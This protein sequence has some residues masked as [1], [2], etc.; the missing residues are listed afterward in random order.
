MNKDKRSPVNKALKALF[1]ALFAVV[2][3]GGFAL[4]VAGYTPTTALS[5][6]YEKATLQ[7][8]EDGRELARSIGSGQ[9]FSDLEAVYNQ[10]Y[11]LR[12]FS[13]KLNNTIDFLQ[14]KSSNASVCMGKNH[15]L[16]EYSYLWDYEMTERSWNGRANSESLRTIVE[17]LSYIREELKESGKHVYVLITPNKADFTE[18]NIPDRIAAAGNRDNENSQ[19]NVDVLKQWLDEYD[20]PYFDSVEYL[21]DSL[22]SDVI[23]FY[24]SGIHYSWAAGYYV[25]QA[26][27]ARIEAETGLPM[28]KFDLRVEAQEGVVF[29]NR[30]LYDLLNTFPEITSAVYADQ[31]QQQVYIDN[32]E[33]SQVSVLMQGGSFLGPYIDMNTRYTGIFR[34]FDII[35]NTIFLPYGDAM[36]SLGSIR[37]VDLTRVQNDQLFIFEVNEASAASMSFGFIDYLAEYLGTAELTTMKPYALVFTDAEAAVSAQPYGVY[38]L[39]DDLPWKFTARRFGCR[40]ENADIYAYGLNLQTVVTDDLRSVVPEGRATVEITVNGAPV[41]EYEPDEAGV[42]HVPAAA[43]ADVPRNGDV[44]LIDCAVNGAYIPQALHPENP[45]SRELALILYSITAGTE[46]DEA[47]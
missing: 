7:V 15:E 32:L 42:I 9:L 40:L 21:R 16:Y 46:E 29:P 13:I 36:V 14:G 45:D 47:A 11:P 33:A 28:P 23:P 27:F 37:D 31:P 4:Y 24:R 35:Q 34:L 41:G 3:V 44:C 38:S 22:P 19:R 26:L 10:D 18:A 30:D 12:P 39:E 25:A 5:G 8:P 1:V 43:L 20:I 17:R 2:L 6:V